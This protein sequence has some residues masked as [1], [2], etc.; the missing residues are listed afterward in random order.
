MASGVCG[1]N[2]RWNE[3]DVL[4]FF[5]PYGSCFKEIKKGNL[6]YT[7]RACRCY[8]YFVIRRN[9][10]A[11]PAT[12]AGGM[13]WTNHYSM[14]GIPRLSP[15]TGRERVFKGRVGGGSPVTSR[16]AETV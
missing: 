11:I 8:S 7:A 4:K 5:S 3:F 14:A 12:K 13:N 6:N 10:L 16:P 1:D 2:D 15:V 9:P